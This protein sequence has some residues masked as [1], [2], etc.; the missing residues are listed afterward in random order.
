[1]TGDRRPFSSG[2]QMPGLIVRRAKARLLRDIGPATGTSE[3][4]VDYHPRLY[5]TF[6]PAE[7]WESDRD[8][9]EI[10]DANAADVFPITGLTP[11]ANSTITIDSTDATIFLEHDQ[12][13]INASSEVADAED[14]A[15]D[16]RG[17][18]ISDAGIA[19]SVLTIHTNLR[20]MD[21]ADL[22]NVIRLVPPPK[23]VGRVVQ[24]ANRWH[25]AT[26]TSGMIVNIEQEDGSEWWDIVSAGC[27]EFEDD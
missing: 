22:G 23:R 7:I 1:M 14:A 5:P 27:G 12:L 17:R 11:G 15:N 13:V 21:V 2:G 8:I 10:N 24:V 3:G 26:L 25:D 19:G 9:D 18:C 4:G 6:G 16:R 20:L